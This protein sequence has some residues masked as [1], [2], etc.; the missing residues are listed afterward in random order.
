MSSSS[1]SFPTDLAIA[2]AASAKPIS[3]I[4]AGMG[5]GEHLLQPFGTDVA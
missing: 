5:L 2:R 4:A 3:E 1:S